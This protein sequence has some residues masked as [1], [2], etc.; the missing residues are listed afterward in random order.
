MT[1]A[2]GEMAKA[3]IAEHRQRYAP[4]WTKEVERMLEA[5]VMPHLKTLRVDSVLRAEVA[6]VVEK[7]AMQPTTLWGCCVPS[8]TGALRQAGRSMT[9]RV[10]Y[11]SAIQVDLA[12]GC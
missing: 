3:Y 1:E 5:D 2:F 9:R 4:A 8:S 10:D 11:E 7:V 6:S 12:N